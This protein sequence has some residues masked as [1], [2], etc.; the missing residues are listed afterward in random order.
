MT[1]TPDWVVLAVPAN[2]VEWLYNELKAAGVASNESAIASRPV[3]PTPQLSMAN[4][5]ERVVDPWALRVR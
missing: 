1:R 3:G 4:G 5:P 2:P